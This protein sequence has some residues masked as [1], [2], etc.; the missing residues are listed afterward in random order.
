MQRL[1]WRQIDLLTMLVVA[2][3]IAYAAGWSIPGSDGKTAVSVAA[4]VPQSLPTLHIPVVDVHSLAE[5]SQGALAIAFIGLIEALSIAKAIAHQTQ[6]K[7]DYNR[8]I[9]AEGLANLHR[10]LL[11]ES[12]RVG[13]VVAVG[14]QLSR[15]CGDP[16]LRDRL[17]SDGR[18]SAAAM[19]WT[20][21]RS[22]S[23]AHGMLIAVRKRS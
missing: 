8:Q 16:V 4:K 2:S 19:V 15:R 17:G 12:A 22:R 5:L 10:W 7:I 13:F 9:L 18:G 23:G 1:H 21:C 3:M 20:R 6:Q 14:D 11:P